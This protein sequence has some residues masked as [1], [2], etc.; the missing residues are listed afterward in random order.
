MDTITATLETLRAERTAAWE[1]YV[2][3]SRY[4]RGDAW[5]SA[6]DAKAAMEEA[7][8]AWQDADDA[9]AAAQDAR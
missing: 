9:L 3:A 5:L 7:F 1:R 6:E 4:Y 8:L 2:T